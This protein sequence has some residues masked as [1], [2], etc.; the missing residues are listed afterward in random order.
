MRTLS[1]QPE[2][3]A[4][5]LLPV[6]LQLCEACQSEGRIYR[7][8]PGWYDEPREDDCGECPECKGDGE[9][10]FETEEVTEE[11]IM[12]AACQC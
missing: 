7:Q 10:L 9:L 6:T 1:S 3:S 11:Q 4:N 8:V 5:S 2:A 12:E